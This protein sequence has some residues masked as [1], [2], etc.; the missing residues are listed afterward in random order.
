MSTNPFCDIA[1]EEAVTFPTKKKKLSYKKTKSRHKKNHTRNFLL[2]LF[3]FFKKLSPFFPYPHKVN[4][5]KH[6]IKIK[7]NCYFIR[8]QGIFE[9]RKETNVNINIKK[10]VC[11]EHKKKNNI[12][13]LN[14]TKVRLKEAGHASE[15]IAVTIGPK[16]AS[17]QL[18][19]AMAIGIDRSIH[20]VTE[21]EL[22]TYIQPLAVSK[23]LAK[24]VEKESPHLVLMGKQSIDDDC[25]QTGPMLAGRL[26]WP[27]ATF[28]SQIKVLSKTVILK[29]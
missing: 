15:L 14:I 6:K 1:I 7:I 10:Y 21:Q 29:T 9:K 5:I 27:Q 19:T 12:Y 16:K 23:I 24:I 2:F 17:E 3:L 28:A 25:S 13:N 20:V 8:G 18:R 22:D 26:G 11:C 4:E